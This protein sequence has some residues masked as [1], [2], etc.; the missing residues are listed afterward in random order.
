[1]QDDILF[2]HFTPREALEFAAE[3]KVSN[4]SPEERRKKIDDLIEVLGLKH[5]QDTVIGS[6]LQKT[7]SG[8]ERK[9]TAIG[10]ELITDPSLIL[11]DE[12]TSGLDSFKAYQIVMLLKKLAREGKTIIATLHQPSSDSF[13]EFDRLLLLSDGYCA[14]QG[15]AKLS[16]KYFREI[17]FKICQFSNPADTYMRILAVDYP[18]KEK[19]ER[20]LVFFKEQYDE[21][22]KHGVEI[23]KELLKL[24][25]P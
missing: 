19:D 15:E 23:E 9:R 20:K 14:Y 21:R 6:P 25:P 5:V 7:I 11:L 17:G 8:G 18:K 3:L 24:E 22:I 12:P 16:A 13:N 1:M 10:V 4:L 2:Q